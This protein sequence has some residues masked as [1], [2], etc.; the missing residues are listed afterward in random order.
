MPDKLIFRQLFDAASSTYT[1]LLGEAHSRQAII[2][3]PVFEQHARDRA[4]V[5]ELGL[6]LVAALDTHCHA[7][8]GDAMQGSGRCDFQQGSVKRLFHSIRD[9]ILSLPDDCLVYPA[10][11]TAGVPWRRWPRSAAALA[12][13]GTPS[14]HPSREVGDSSGCRLCASWPRT[15]ALSSLTS[16]FASR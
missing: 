12:R 8:H 13:R 11:A 1:Y 6:R 16:S 5:E 14:P 9:Q 10:K 3:D 2:I 15:R 4:L 7:D